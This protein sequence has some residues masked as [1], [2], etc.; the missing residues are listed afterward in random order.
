MLLFIMLCTQCNLLKPVYI[1]FIKIFI[2]FTSQ[3]FDIGER[4]L[5][6]NVIE[7]KLDELF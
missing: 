1:S 4:P 5:K 6:Y 3:S 7:L 2:W